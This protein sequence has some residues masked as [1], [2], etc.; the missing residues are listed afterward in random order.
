MCLF[1]P[2]SQLFRLFFLLPCPRLHPTQTNICIWLLWSKVGRQACLFIYFL[3]SF[4][5]LFIG[6]LANW[7]KADKS[8]AVQ[9]T[10]F[11]FKAQSDY[12]KGLL[13]LKSRPFRKLQPC[14][15]HPTYHWAMIKVNEVTS[16]LP[17]GHAHSRCFVLCRAH[18][19]CFGFPLELK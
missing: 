8:M 2:P 14:V 10:A 6:R 17:L 18:S 4:I 12:N 11:G 3:C 19:R 9:A 5:Y 1:L 15:T 13:D 7:K 16:G